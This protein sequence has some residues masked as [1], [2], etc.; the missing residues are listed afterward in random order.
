MVLVAKLPRNIGLGGKYIAQVSAAGPAS[1]SSGGFTL[2]TGLT[3]IDRLVCVARDTRMGAP[4]DFVRTMAYTIAAGVVTVLVSVIQL[5]ATNTYAEIAD[6]Q[7][8][9]T[10]TFDVIAVGEP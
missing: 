2:D 5:S 8:L 9:A 7:N 1:Y 4:N 3:T 6:A 10:I